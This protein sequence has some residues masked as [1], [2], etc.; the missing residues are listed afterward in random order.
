M[1]A[2]PL[3][4]LYTAR[5]VKRIMLIIIGVLY[6]NCDVVKLLTL[7]KMVI[8]NINKINEIM[9]LMMVPRV[10]PNSSFIFSFNGRVG[11]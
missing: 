9:I 4:E 5:A 10:L 2:I 8:A 7:Y 3:I 11:L 6:R 1:I